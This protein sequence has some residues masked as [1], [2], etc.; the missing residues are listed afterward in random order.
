MLPLRDDNPTTLTPIITLGLIGANLLVFLWQLSWGLQ[1]S[2]LAYGLIPAELVHA[3]D[4]EFLL[5]SRFEGT[6]TL[7]RNLD[8]AALTIVTSMFLHGSWLH[9]L[10]NMWW[11]WIFG[12]NI[13]D[14][15]GHGRF[16]VFYVVC[17]VAAA[18][19]QVAMGADSRTPMVGASGALSGVLGAYLVAYPHSRVF[20][21]TTFFIIGTVELPAKL[22]LGFWFALQIFNGL[23]SLGPS[24][25]GGGVAYAAH[26]GGFI[27][28]WILIR[29]MEPSSS[30]PTR[31]R[32][33]PDFMDR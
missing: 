1:A 28:G 12:N 22:V 3:A 8:P 4:I 11:L 25:S 14:R 13:E 6:E 31:W 15:L 26:V 32:E 30:G 21:L 9:V 24:V 7:V 17:G 19:A 27:A 5:R 2:A 23:V 18:A 33:R 20:C 10:G 16:I 29:L